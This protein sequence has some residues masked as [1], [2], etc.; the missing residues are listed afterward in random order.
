MCAENIEEQ[1]LGAPGDLQDIH[2]LNAE[3]W[4]IQRHDLARSWELAHKARQLASPAGLDKA[5][6]PFG[7][8]E[9]LRTEA[10]VLRLENRL[11]EALM[12]SMELLPLVEQAGHTAI[13]AHVLHNIALTYLGLGDMSQ[14]LDYF[15]RQKQAAE[16][17]SDFEFVASAL[18]GIGVV[19]A[20]LQQYDESLDYFEQS[21]PFYKK[22]GTLHWV[23]AALNNIFYIHFRMGNI[24]QALQR[25]LEA[26]RFSHEIQD[27]YAINTVNTSIAEIY[28]AQGNAAQ[29]LVHLQEALALFPEIIQTNIRLD[30]LLQYG[31]ALYQNGQAEAA[32][33]ELHQ[34]LALAEEHH[35]KRNQVD[36][37]LSLSEIYEK[38]GR[39]DLALRHHQQFYKVREEI[40]SEES[41]RKT[42]N[43]E[44]LQRTQAARQ[45]ADTY[46]RLYA[47]ERQFST[48]L[49]AEVQHRTED[50]RRAYERLDRLDRSK[51]DFIAITAH[52]LRTPL[53]ALKGYSQILHL[54][55][56]ISGDEQRASLL[57]GIVGGAN[58]LLEIVNTM[59]LMAKIDS[60]ALEIYPEPLSLH[61]VVIQIAGA[62]QAVLA[63][64]QQTL[65]IDPQMQTLPSIE[66][67]KAVLTIVLGNIIENAIKYTPD[68][69]CIDISGAAWQAAPRPDLPEQAVE[70]VVSDSG[71]GI[72]P[73]A[74]ELVFTKFYRTDTIQTHS[75]GRTKFKGAG[76]GLGLAVA[77]G[78]IEAHQGRLW[79]ESAGHD[80]H[81]L[82]GSQFHIVLPVQ[83][84]QS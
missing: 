68:G 16:Q 73:Q 18:L 48:Q 15:L 67:D 57:Q 24:E 58:R 21:L 1:S 52:E 36:L 64:R 60:Q 13:L 54:D 78:I 26:L 42:R 20:E 2:S 10:F 61:A 8:L 34:A 70:I 31:Q 19:Y 75:S 84:P 56:A 55:P 72:A 59:L 27:A 33:T 53:T 12:A 5:A 62:L 76:P 37:H 22:A 66:G 40:A 9:A 47:Q 14:T 23:S 45:E 79:A 25:G 4:A 3:A 77:R 43:L 83:Q 35:Y 38:E 29:A 30:T 65:T 49:E 50:L 39:F 17:S 32:L 63:E 74:L 69:G 81:A 28:L 80:E 82:P 51:S 11:D 44:V 7:L 71:I 46:A 6:D 41:A